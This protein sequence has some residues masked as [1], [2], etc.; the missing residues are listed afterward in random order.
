MGQMPD[1]CD[2]NSPG[3]SLSEEEARLQLLLLRIGALEKTL[4][5]LNTQIREIRLT[6]ARDYPERGKVELLIGIRMPNF[7]EI[8]RALGRKHETDEYAQRRLLESLDPM[9]ADPD[10]YGDL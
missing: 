2:A 8:A 1:G 9:M 6:Y 3:G 5:T 7:P 10:V 4:H